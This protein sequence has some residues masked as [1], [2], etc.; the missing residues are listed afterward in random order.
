MGSLKI[1]IFPDPVLRL[2]ASSVA[3]FDGVAGTLR[4][5]AETMY[6][7]SGIGLAA[8]QVGISLRMLV[9]DAGDGLREFVNPH[10]IS[11]SS[12]KS[13]MEEGCL[14][15]PGVGVVVSRPARIK[16]KAQNA[17]GELFTEE[18]DGLAA[19]AIQHEADHLSG[20]LILDYLDPVRYFLTARKF[21]AKGGL[22]LKRTCEVVC[23]D[24]KRH[25]RR[26]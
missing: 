15:V 22:S 2:K 5:M 18:F 8:P 13:K 17:K 4:A 11:R 12:A 25:T 20:K 14:S 7:S 26:A 21:R 10:I 23:N 24:G 1:R 16:V 19:R 9:I 3:D 6:A